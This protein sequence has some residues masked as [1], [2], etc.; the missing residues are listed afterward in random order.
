MNENK[1]RGIG[2]KHALN[3]VKEAFIKER[4]FKIHVG[5]AIIVIFA[6]F[7]YQLS[8]LEWLFILF[9]T[10]SV[11]VT[12]LI[13][14]V[15]ERIIDYLNPAYHPKAKLIKDMAAAVVLITVVCSIIIGGIIFLPKI[16]L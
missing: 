11:L 15:I 1:K 12:E 14:S 10:Q 5:V 16:L 13:N 7:Y 4:N 3:G 8:K 2:L 6:S 9:S